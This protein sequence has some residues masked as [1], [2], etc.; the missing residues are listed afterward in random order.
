MSEVMSEMRSPRSRPSS[1]VDVRGDERDEVAAVAPLELGGRQAAESPE[2]PV[3]DER[4]QLERDEVVA[5]L[6]AVAKQTACHGAD[7]HRHD[8]ARERGRHAVREHREHPVATEHRDCRR[9]SV[10]EKSHED[11]QHHKSHERA[12]QP[13]EPPHHPHATTPFV[14]PN[15]SSSRWARQSVA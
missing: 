4:E 3:A 1:L 15:S 2:H 6:L 5:R 10:A 14:V 7:G 11:G 8:E 9:A 13:H 12:H